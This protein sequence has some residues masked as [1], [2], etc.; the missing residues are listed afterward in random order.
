MREKETTAYDEIK[1]AVD[2]GKELID[3][4]VLACDKLKEA[5]DEV[6]RLIEEE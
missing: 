2:S 1:L 4:Y 6:H 5:W 3:G